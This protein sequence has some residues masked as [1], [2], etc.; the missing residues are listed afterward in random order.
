MSAAPPMRLQAL[1]FR[2]FDSLRRIP[3]IPRV[4]RYFGNLRG[5]AN[6]SFTFLFNG[7]IEAAA[8]RRDVSDYVLWS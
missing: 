2:S 8:F 1:D 7:V 3:I 4:A 6:A 5:A